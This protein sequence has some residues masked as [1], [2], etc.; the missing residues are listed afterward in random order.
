MMLFK[1]I[2][3]RFFKMLSY[4]SLTIFNTEKNSENVL[5]IGQS[6]S[7]KYKL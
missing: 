6:Q 4:K 3:D 1:A 5:R 7:G 2:L